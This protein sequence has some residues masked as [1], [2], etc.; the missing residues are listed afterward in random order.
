MG[1]YKYENL[2][3]TKQK[4]LLEIS[5]CVIQNIYIYIYIYTLLKKDPA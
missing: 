4:M 2:L 3:K 5:E 1:I